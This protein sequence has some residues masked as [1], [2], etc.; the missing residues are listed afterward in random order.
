M[1]IKKT[2]DYRDFYFVEDEASARLLHK[3][4]H[5]QHHTYVRDVASWHG[6]GWYTFVSETLYYN[7]ACCHNTEYYLVP[8]DEFLQ[9]K[10]NSINELLQEIETIKNQLKKTE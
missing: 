10:E 8:V 1:S 3:Q 2:I 5:R 4:N 9:D 7:D 6:P